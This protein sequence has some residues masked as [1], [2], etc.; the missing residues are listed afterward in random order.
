MNCPD[1]HSPPRSALKHSTAT[2]LLTIDTWSQ[3]ASLEQLD[4]PDDLI[5]AT[6]PTGQ[7]PSR[8]HTTEGET[9][10]A[11]ITPTSSAATS[12]EDTAHIFRFFDLP[13][14]LRDKIYEQPVLMDHWLVPFYPEQDIHIEAEKL[15][16]SLLLVN[17]QFRDEYTEMCEDQ[18]ALLLHDA[19]RSLDDASILNEVDMLRS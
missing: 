17:R 3:S 5:M 10:A 11:S 12:R 13:R 18:Q 7:S 15:S 16:M 8:R 19:F 1:N 14:E 6:N 2:D 9:S 4:T